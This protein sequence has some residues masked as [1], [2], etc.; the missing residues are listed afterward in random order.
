MSANAFAVIN[1]ATGQIVQEVF[2]AGPD[3]ARAAIDAAVDAFAGLEG[4]DRLRAIA[5][6]S[7]AG[8]TRFC[9]TSRRSRD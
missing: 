3:E 7:A 5:T 9:A 6:C 1:P 2:D 8:A 4:E